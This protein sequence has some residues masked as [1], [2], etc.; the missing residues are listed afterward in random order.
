MAT[1]FNT[2]TFVSLQKRYTMAIWKDIAGYEGLYQVSNEGRVRALNR[3]VE[4][5]WGTRMELKGKE[6]KEVVDGLGYSR[7]SLSKNGKVKAFKIHRLVANAFLN[8]S[9]Q[10]NHIDANK[11][12]NNVIN[13]EYCTQKENNIHAELNNLRP[14]KRKQL[15]VC[16][17][18]GEVYTGQSDLARK[19][20]VSAPMV[21]GYMK[22]HLN[23]I[24]GFTFKF[25]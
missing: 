25:L 21:T 8:G 6:I 24:K 15:I 19:I 3:I 22:G 5:R 1:L 2:N 20:G 13:L 17:Q 10:V 18:T 7:V 9:G 11:Q 12:N 16:E 14:K 23:H 4:S